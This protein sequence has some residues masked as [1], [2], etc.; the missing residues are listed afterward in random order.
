M[1]DRRSHH[2][3][4]C[5]GVLDIRE[6]NRGICDNCHKETPLS[7]TTERL[8]EAATQTVKQMSPAEKAKLRQQLNDGSRKLMREAGIPLIPMD[9]VVLELLHELK[10]PVTRENYLKIAYL[11]DPPEE[12]GAELEAELPEELRDWSQFDEL[13]SLCGVGGD[14]GEPS[15]RTPK[16]YPVCSECG[17]S[18]R[19]KNMLICRDCRDGYVLN[20]EDLKILKSMGVKR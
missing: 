3:H 5:D 18:T 15:Y 8:M 1:T 20:D 14:C 6:F 2:C 16:G 17:R 10:M 7:L 13:N 11:G 4:Q 9:D 19:N 12:W